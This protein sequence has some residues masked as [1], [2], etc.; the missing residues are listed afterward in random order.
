MKVTVSSLIGISFLAVASWAMAQTG[1]G[2]MMD[3]GSKMAGHGY[4]YGMMGGYTT[5]WV[6][7]GLVKV[8]VVAIGLWL[9]LRITRAVER[10][11][12]SKP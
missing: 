11:A 6:L 2:E 7:C 1:G 9:L 5:W 8:A 4:G 3:E 10:I 12:G